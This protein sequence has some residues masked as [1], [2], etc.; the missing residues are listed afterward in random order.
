MCW[1]ATQPLGLWH[2]EAYAGVWLFTTN[3]S[4]YGGQKRKQD[5]LTSLQAHV[6]YTFRQRLWLAANATWYRG[7]STSLD[8]VPKADLQENTRLGL[9]LS[10][11]VGARQSLKLTW[12]D[13]AST[14]IG[15]DFTTW[16]VAWQLL[17]FD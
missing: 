4:F 2:L 16:G 9:T 7:G 12:N 13:G 6:S 15:G 3:D 1:P 11:P 5:P 14:R 17:W 10:L 8:G